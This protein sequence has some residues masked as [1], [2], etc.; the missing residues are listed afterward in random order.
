MRALQNRKGKL[1]TQGKGLYFLK[2]VK[3]GLKEKLLFAVRMSIPHLGLVRQIGEVA[4]CIVLDAFE[5][6]GAEV[7][8]GQEA[9]TCIQ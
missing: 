7:R 3:N 4:D 8:A 5:P 2:R 1:V 9:Y 6:F